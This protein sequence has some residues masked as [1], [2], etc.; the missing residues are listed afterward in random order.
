MFSVKV[1]GGDLV[2]EKNESLIIGAGEVRIRVHATAVNRADLMQRK[3]LYPPPPGASDVL[4]LECSGE[5]IEVGNNVDSF[6]V[7]DLVCALLSGGGYSE[8]VVVPAG[9]VLAI[10]KG[11]NVVTAAAIPEVFATAYMNLYMEAGLTLGEHVLIHAAGSGVGTAAIQLCRITKNPCFVTVGNDEKLEKCVALG[12]E[13]GWNRSRGSFVSAVRQWAPVDVV[14]DL[15]GASFFSDNL[16]VLD[17][18][19]R[20]CLVGLL[21]GASTEIDLASVLMK[22]NKL[23]GSTLRGRSIPKKSLVMEGLYDQ[24]WNAFET[25]EISPVVHEIIPIKDV[26]EAHELVAEN[27]TFG[28][29]ILRVI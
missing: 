16:E 23:I 7:G 21:G 25:Q 2:W 22:R 28:K 3:G 14:L 6:E 26:K 9:Q 8:E 5:V 10:P 12:A 15:V 18:D 17:I 27:K 11:M 13:R 4:G 24:F 20:L 1:K 29:V 19:G